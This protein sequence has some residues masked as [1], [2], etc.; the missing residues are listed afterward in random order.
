MGIALLAGN[1]FA[2][3][4]KG[5]VL[6]FKFAEVVPAASIYGRYE[7]KF[8][9]LIEER[10]GGMVKIAN[11][12]GGAMGGEKDVMEGLRMGSVHISL[13]GLT[14]MPFLDVT[15]GP[16]VFRDKDH[17]RKVFDGE[18]GQ[19][20]KDRVLKE[21]GGLRL[22]DYVYFG[23]RELTTKKHSGK[24]AG[25]VEGDEDPGDGESDLHRHLESAGS[26]SG[27]HG[28]A[29]GVYGIAAGNNRCTGESSCSRSLIT[30]CLRYRSTWS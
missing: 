16:F 13:V 28:D 9:K 3:A 27:P 10:T 1:A 11:F 20:W 19:S 8:G 5:P 17:A 22:I 24:D 2:A 15:W 23:P 12:A 4:A 30:V 25:R 7:A 18:I 29:G 6:E 14:L 26:E 21:S